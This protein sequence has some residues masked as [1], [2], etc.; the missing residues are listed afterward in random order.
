MYNGFLIDFFTN[1]GLIPATIIA[2]TII[3]LFAML[4]ILILFFIAYFIFIKEKKDKNLLFLSITFFSVVSI[5]ILFFVILRNT[6]YSSLGPL[7]ILFASLL[8]FSLQS[9]FKNLEKAESIREKEIKENKEKNNILNTI[10]HSLNEDITYSFHFLKNKS[11]DD[12]HNNYGSLNF[13]SIL[14]EDLYNY[15]MKLGL[16]IGKMDLIVTIFQLDKQI[17]KN[18][19]NLKDNYHELVKDKKYG[20]IKELNLKIY[21]DYFYYILN[22]FI[23]EELHKNGTN[24]I[25][26]KIGTL[27]DNNSPKECYIQINKENLVEKV[28]NYHETKNLSDLID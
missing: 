20:L 11:P 22:V 1:F 15:C 13:E 27:L 14:T 6:N 3:T 5:I 10:L 23:L 26:D 12:Y 2:T 17:H 25:N 9:Y 7:F 19:I 24:H 8:V 4:I 21:T 16:D 18:I 28:K